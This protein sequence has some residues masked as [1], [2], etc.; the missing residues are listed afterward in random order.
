MLIL[1]FDTERLRD[2]CEDEDQA[3]AQLPDIVAIN[4]KRRLSDILAAESI[5]DLPLGNPRSA[6]ID[7]V[8][9]VKVDLGDEYCL[10]LQANQ[11]KISETMDGSID[12][13]KIKRVK[14]VK[15]EGFTFE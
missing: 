3:S 9:C 2:L 7:T 11:E 5:M 10:V 15:I 6:H 1:A 8:E 13:P 12:W 14:L 4:L